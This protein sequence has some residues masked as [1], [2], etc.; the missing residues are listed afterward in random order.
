MI[1]KIF[2]VLCLVSLLVGVPLGNTEALGTAVLT[3]AGRAIEVTLSLCGMLCL[4]SGLLRVFAV[5][6]VVSWLR[7]LLSPLL[8]LF[9]PQA[10]KGAAMG[11]I[12]ANL[13][14]NLLGLGNAATPAA[15]RAMQLL[16]ESN[17]HP[18][19]ATAEQIT[20]M[21]L[22]TAPL[23]LLPANLL[24]LRSAAG[25]EAPYAILLPVWAVSLGALL[26]TLLLTALLRWCEGRRERRFRTSANGELRKKSTTARVPA[27]KPL[28][29]FSKRGRGGGSWEH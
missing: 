20:L 7:R 27:E 5:A 17:P 14:A 29:A 2:G 28:G 4:W 23:T 8:R 24:A 3:G 22:N 26:L 16:Q 25:S 18:E 6:G 12:S 9:F 10:S 21:V 11:E 1:G 19:R 15:L 13:A